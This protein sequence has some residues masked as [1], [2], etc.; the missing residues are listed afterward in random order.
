[1]NGYY[2]VRRIGPGREHYR[3]YCILENG[4][5]EELA[6]RGFDGPRIVVIN[7]LCKRNATLFSNA[8]Y[9]RHVRDHGSRCHATL[10]RP[11]AR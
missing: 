6:E 3:L 7:G 2:E 4:T 11:V 10:P 9:K 5:P 8:E 1:M